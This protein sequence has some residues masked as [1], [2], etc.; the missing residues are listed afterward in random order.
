M[1]CSRLLPMLLLAGTVLA[2]CTSKSE[3]FSGRTPEQV[4]TVMA[5]V[6]QEPDYDNW[7][8]LENNVWVDSNYDRI[9]INRRIKRDFHDEGANAQRQ[10]ETIDM[11]F[12]L[13]RTN[14]PAV[15][16]TVRS[17]M[18]PVKAHAALDQFFA[19]MHQLLD[20]ESVSGIDVVE[21]I[22]LVPADPVDESSGE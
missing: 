5:T 14:P 13:E 20:P 3:V 19:E 15:T 10:I 8:L 17:R 1:P 12:V 21:M 22:E 11:Q 4:W 16:G 2:G 9:E 18:I 6:A 7:I